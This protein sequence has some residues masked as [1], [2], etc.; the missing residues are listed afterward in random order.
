MSKSESAFLSDIQ[1]VNLSYLMLAQR[2]LQENLPVGMYRL[3]IDEDIAETILGLSPAQIV[4]LAS[5]SSLLCNFRLNDYQLLHTLSQDV[6]GGVLQ[7]AHTTIL[8]TQR[9]TVGV[10]A[11]DA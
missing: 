6:L 1:E 3:G 5:S 4:R 11:E 7:E 8:L 9:A 10:P 2:L